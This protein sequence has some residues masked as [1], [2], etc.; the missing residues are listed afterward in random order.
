M[1]E[2]RRDILLE[3]AEAVSDG[4]EVDW[5]HET[6]KDSELSGP[7]QELALLQRIR[8]S[9]IEGA[10]PRLATPQ[11]P[12]QAREGDETKTLEASPIQLPVPVKVT[13]PFTWGHLRVLE[14]IG[15]GGFGE[16]YR[17]FDPTLQVEFALKL[18]KQVE[19]EDAE[20]QA[21][22]LSEARRLARVRHPNVLIV[23]GADIHNGRIGLWT[24][25]LP[26]KTLEEYLGAGGKLGAREA[27][28]IGID[29]CRALAAVHAAG[30][31]HRDVK[32]TN[33]MK[34]AG[35]RIVLMDFGSVGEL[36]LPGDPSVS[37]HVQG[38]LVSMAPEQL[39]GDVSGPPIDIYGLGVLLY[40]MVSGR[41]PVEA[42]GIEELIEK[43]AR[44]ERVPLRDRRADLPT[45]FVRVIEKALEPDPANRF[46]TAGAME[47]ALAAT[48]GSVSH[49]TSGGARR[50]QKRRPAERI[51]MVALGILIVAAIGVALRSR[52][53]DSSNTTP[54]GTLSHTPPPLMATAALYRRAGSVDEPLQ[55]G[56]RV[57]PGDRLYL[58]L[59]G[60][61]PMYVYVLNEDEMGDVFVL[62]PLPGL[63]PSNPLK[64][65]ERHRLPGEVADSVYYWNVTSVGKKE[66]ILAIA[67]R[68]PVEE[69]EREIEMLPRAVRGRPLAEGKMSPT[70]VGR[71]RGIGGVAADTRPSAGRDNL[72]LSDVLKSLAEGPR[73]PADLWVWQAQLD[74]PEPA[75]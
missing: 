58:T 51:A 25:L 67:S 8:D 57:A 49:A 19:G 54:P 65:S 4:K 50:A 69:V 66:S 48:L 27:A 74:N 34:E 29:L 59:E 42:S 38:T 28:L 13:P 45:D 75:P 52:P 20:A 6:S 68:K 3:A 7:L 2:G 32:T 62:F 10:G 55:P 33:V 53:W 56:A 14:K 21:R 63:E 23:H 31:V 71:L 18:R 35:G 12:T 1:D 5:D 47:L 22:F 73:W 64:G 24:D 41:F 11:S 43:H 70:A 16:V 39:R 37:R 44:R 15:E 60:S 36:P 46:Q 9:M 40:R 30:L 61:E 72:R 17:A 26:G